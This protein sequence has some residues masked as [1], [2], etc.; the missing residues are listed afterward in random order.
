MWA[1][2]YLNDFDHFVK[3]ELGCPAYERYVDDFLLF[4]DDKGQLHAWR[5]AIIE[6]LAGL[7]LKLHEERA[8]VFPTRTGIPFLGFRVYADHR[9]VKRRNVVHF[10]RRLRSLLYGLIER[11]DGR[12]RLTDGIRAWVNHVRNAD[13]WGLRRSVLGGIRV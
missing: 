5:E 8:Q 3:R 6:R 7:R 1:N 10:R 11:R 2:V 9:R 4:S 12:A 13:S